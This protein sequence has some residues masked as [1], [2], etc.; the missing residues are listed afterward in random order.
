MPKAKGKKYSAAQK[1]IARVAPPRNKITGADF[2]G[3]RNR[4]KG[5]K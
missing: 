4:G 2:K 3:L 5:K 1:K